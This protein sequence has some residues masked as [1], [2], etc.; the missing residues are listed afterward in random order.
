MAICPLLSINVMRPGIEDNQQEFVE[1]QEEKCMF[2]I[3]KSARTEVY[4]CSLVAL[5]I[6]NLPNYRQDR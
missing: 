6:Y 4:T 3:R 5:A 1:C 2:F